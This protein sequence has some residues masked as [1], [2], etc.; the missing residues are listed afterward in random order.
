MQEQVDEEGRNL[1][2]RALWRLNTPPSHS[3]IALSTHWH[4]KGYQGCGMDGSGLE[5]FH[6]RTHLLTLYSRP[7]P[8]LFSGS[9]T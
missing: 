3:S 8:A 4:F 1:K 2:G 5:P 9:G 6:T 7:Q